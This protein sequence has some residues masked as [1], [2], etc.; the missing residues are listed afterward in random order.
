MFAAHHVARAWHVFKRVAV[1]CYDDGLIHAGNLAYMSLLAIFPFFLTGAAA[2]T[3]VG[4]PGEQA[5]AVRAVLAALPAGSDAAGVALRPVR[6]ALSAAGRGH[7]TVVVDLPRSGDLVV[8]TLAR[9]ALVAV[10]GV[11]RRAWHKG[12]AFVDG[13]FGEGIAIVHFAACTRE[14]GPHKQATLRLHE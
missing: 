1:G 3:L 5:A 11:K 4:E 6:E 13:Q 7:D 14:A 10:V 2:F 12:H 9:C 8:E